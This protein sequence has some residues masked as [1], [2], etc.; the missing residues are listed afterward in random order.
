MKD[1]LQI[2]QLLQDSSF[3]Y[4]IAI[5]MDSC[6]SYVSPNYDRSFRFTNSTLLGKHFSVTLHEEDIPLCEKAGYECFSHP[7]KL[8]PVTL[9]KLDGNGGFISTQWEM[10]SFFD[11]NGQPQG[12]YC[13]GYNISEFVDTRSRL[14]SA[15]NQLDSIGFI[16]S[17]VVRRP[18]A[19]IISL[20]DMI[21][22][23]TTGAHLNQLCLMLKQSS[24]E[25]DEAIKE[26]SNKTTK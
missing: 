12:I 7:G 10:Q 20:T 17:H 2:N 22:E 21:Q 13:I 15:H 1:Y 24:A 4:T 8:V 25:L 5:G 11:E 3:F 26:I 14:D 9:R 19:N 16:Q 23:E 6:Y 18:L